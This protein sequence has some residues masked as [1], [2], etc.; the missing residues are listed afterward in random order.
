M[1]NPFALPTCTMKKGDQRLTVNRTDRAQ[2]EADG[3]KHASDNDPV[4]AAPAVH[5]G[6]TI[7]DIDDAVVEEEE[8]DDREATDNIEEVVED[9]SSVGHASKKSKKKSKRG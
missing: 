2:Y 7:D 8:P 4:S 6:V 5:K 9:L 3:W 1:T